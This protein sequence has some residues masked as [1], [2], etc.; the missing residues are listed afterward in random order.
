MARAAATDA[1]GPAHP[2][3]APRTLPILIHGDAAFPG[4]GVVAETLNLSRLPGYDAAA[5]S[6][7]S[8]TTSSGSPPGR[9]SPTAPLRER[10]GARLQDPDRARQRRRPRGLHRGGAAGVRRTG[11]RFRRDFLI[12]LVGY[13]RYGHNEGDEPAFTQP[14]MYRTIAGTRRCASMWARD[15]ERARARRCREAPDAIV[16]RYTGVLEQRSRARCEP[17]RGRVRRYPEPAPR[18]AAR[19]VATGRAARAAARAQR[20]A[21]ARPGVHRAPQAR[22]GRERRRGACSTTPRRT[23]RLGAPPRSWRWPRSSRTAR[24]SG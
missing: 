18:G 17:E 22:R 6:T 8:P 4:Q 19:H 1:G 20:R 16:K 15:L 24:R 2:A 14:V 21:A 3:A 9:T 13:R 12:D 5:R 7:S 11:R 23:D 10:P